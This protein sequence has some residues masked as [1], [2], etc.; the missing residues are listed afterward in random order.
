[1]SSPMRREAM[2]VAGAVAVAWALGDGERDPARVRGGGGG[3]RARDLGLG[4]WRARGVVVASVRGNEWEE[5]EPGRRG[6]N[7]EGGEETFGEGNGED[8]GGC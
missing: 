1:M 4:F 3:G 8:G 6:R 2:A 5:L 7:S